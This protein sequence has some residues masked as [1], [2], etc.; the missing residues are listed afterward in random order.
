M[1][2]LACDHSAVDLKKEVM[3]LLDEKGLTYKDFGTYSTDSCDYPIYSARAARAV[4]NGECEKGI[5]I[6]GTG[7]GVSLVANKVKGIRCALCGDPFSAEMSRRH[8]NANMLAIGAR[9]IGSELAKLIV[10]TWLET[11]YESDERHAR[12]IN[13]ITAVENGEDL[14]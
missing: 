8:N 1:I 9:V 7:I 6:C 3:A 13:M 11:P 5:V 10:K 2:A 4:A 12:R 14:G